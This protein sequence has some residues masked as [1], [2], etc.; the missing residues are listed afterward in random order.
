MLLHILI[1]KYPIFVSFTAFILLQKTGIYFGI[2]SFIPEQ[3]VQA[4]KLKQNCHKKMKPSLFCQA[5]KHRSAALI[6]HLN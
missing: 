5:S 3:E 1:A 6:R 4:F 2:T